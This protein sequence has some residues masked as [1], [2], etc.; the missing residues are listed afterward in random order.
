MVTQFI[1]LGEK[2]M[3]TAIEN[4]E[5]NSSPS[6]SQ[7]TEGE[8]AAFDLDTIAEEVIP[9]LNPDD[10]FSTVEL[11]CKEVDNVRSSLGWD[12]A[13]LKLAV[14]KRLRGRA[15]VYSETLPSTELSWDEWKE[16]LTREFERD[17]YE[18]LQVMLHR[19]KR[20][21][22]SYVKYFAEKNMLLRA[23][24]IEGKDA[25]SCIV[26]GIPGSAV[27]KPIKDKNF[28]NPQDLLQHL[29]TLRD[30]VPSQGTSLDVTSDVRCFC[31]GQ[32]G[33]Q[34]SICRMKKTAFCKYCKK[35]GHLVQAC[36]RVE[37]SLWGWAP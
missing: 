19:T 1:Q 33:H 22:E 7:N 20:P 6:P 18:R 3:A 29:S 17:F 27:R 34:K 11:W 5:E 30:D 31:C 8:S 2:T 15:S 24:K 37:A 35:R 36:K 13:S 23:C 12:D 9:E 16:K 14:S 4:V 25:V 26:A 21:H 10:R 28:E 32:V